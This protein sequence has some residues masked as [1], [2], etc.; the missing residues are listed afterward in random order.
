VQLED[1][2]KLA[3]MRHQQDTL[4]FQQELGFC[5]Q[6]N[7]GELASMKFARRTAFHMMPNEANGHGKRFLHEHT[8][9]RGFEKV[10]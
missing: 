8:D 2:L 1:A 4:G 10:G 7:G 6:A 3:Y 5:A 9:G